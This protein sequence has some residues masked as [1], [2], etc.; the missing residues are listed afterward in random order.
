MKRNYKHIAIIAIGC[1]I[2]VT[3]IVLYKING[4]E[5]ME[6]NNDNNIF[7]EE[8]ATAIVTSKEEREEENEIVVEIKGEVKNP[9]VYW[10]KEGCIVEELINMAGGVTE[11]ADLSTINRAEKLNNH[12]AIYIPN[13][14][15]VA[16]NAVV[17]NVSAVSSDGK[18]NINI[19]T[20]E[21][22]QKLSGVGPARAED[23]IEYREKVG[24]FKSLEEIKNV[25]GIGEASFDKIKEKITI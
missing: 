9:N 14:N 24:G 4:K 8:E 25:K 21:E 2:F 18:I 6:L 13:K 10:I 11:L 20:S 17:N 22:L 19:A 16:N 3:M 1:I 15:E 23:I 12:Q 5:E 7:V